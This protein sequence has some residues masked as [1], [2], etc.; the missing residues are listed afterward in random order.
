[1]IEYYFF[2]I[3]VGTNTKGV[4]GGGGIVAS[5]SVQLKED[6]GDLSTNLSFF[7]IWL[8]VGWVIQPSSI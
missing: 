5:V 2:L 8:V 3:I 1:V 7:S 4:D 6:K